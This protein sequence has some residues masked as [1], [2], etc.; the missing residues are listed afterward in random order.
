MI[1]LSQSQVEWPLVLVVDDSPD[2]LALIHSLLR[3]RYRVKSASSGKKGLLIAQSEPAPNLIL[4]D[5]MMPGMD[6]H[7]VCSLLK[8]NPRTRDI[9]VIFLTAKADIENEEKAFSLGAVDYVTKP[10]GASVLLA[11]VKA[12]IAADAQ[13]RSLE[14][15]FR[16]VIEYAPVIFLIADEDL[17]IVQTNA[18]A[19]QHFGYG[20]EELLGLNLM[21]L[22]PQSVRF[23]RTEG[24]LARVQPGGAGVEFNPELVCVR[25][26]GSSFPG[27]ATFSRLDTLHGLLHTVVLVNATDKKETLR[28][29]S[30]SQESLRELAA[31]NETARENERKHIAREVHDELGQV[32]TALRMSLS[33]MPMQFGTRIPGLIDSVDAMKALVDR[34]IKGVRNI[35]TVLRPEALNMG[36]VPAIEWLRDEFLRHNEVR[37]V[38]ECKGST[39]PIDEMRAMLIYRIVQESL[40]NISRYA[41]AS[42]VKI[43]IHF[44]P[45]EI[46]VSISD[47]GCG[48]D[49]GEVMIRKTFGLLGMRE[50][51][52]TLGG[53]LMILSRP[54]RGTTIAVKVPL[55]PQ[56]Q[57][58]AP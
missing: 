7:E 58:C 56:L 26:D 36:L 48:F 16:D 42:E 57:E 51:A 20:R 5:V 24:T 35:A 29:L 6:G 47:D 45:K 18:Q 33:L 32:M 13:R 38:L 37:C 23:M 49:P 41:K 27:S 8:E 10:I 53:D 31:I 54:G 9:P 50:R 1:P 34:A 22:L 28:K 4:L 11:R 21:D 39:D 40:T 2:I 44:T 19:E 46:D 25:K 12:H 55:H 30:E 15:M 43:L 14:G 17:N 52:L 3:E